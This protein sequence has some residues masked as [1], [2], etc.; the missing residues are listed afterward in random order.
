MLRNR[1]CVQNVVQEEF[2]DSLRWLLAVS[3]VADSES[4]EIRSLP[5]QQPPWLVPASGLNLYKIGDSE[6]KEE[7]GCGSLEPGL[8][9]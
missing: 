6:G 9:L 4:R 3:Q 1:N 2:A 8:C 5:G 7:Q